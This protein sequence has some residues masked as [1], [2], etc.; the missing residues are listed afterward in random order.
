[1]AIRPASSHGSKISLP[2]WGFDSLDLSSRLESRQMCRSWVADLVDLFALISE[3]CCH[4]VPECRS[5]RIRRPTACGVTPIHLAIP[6]RETTSSTSRT[7]STP[8]SCNVLLAARAAVTQSSPSAVG[9]IVV[10]PAKRR[11][12]VKV[13]EMWATFHLGD[14]TSGTCVLGHEAATLWFQVP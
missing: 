12:A 6:V 11:L 5:P 14:S 8:A 13:V 7:G 3:C 9:V 10:T 2:V 1:M 4:F